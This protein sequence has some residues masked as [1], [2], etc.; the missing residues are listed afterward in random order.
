MKRFGDR[1]VTYAEFKDKIEEAKR[2]EELRR[3]KHPKE[4]RI[5]S[6]K[7]KLET[8]IEMVLNKPDPSSKCMKDLQNKKLITEAALKNSRKKHLAEI[9]EL[10]AK[11]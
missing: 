7:E 8:S 11:L 4:I 2:E 5:G 9:A 1:A 10:N 3:K 6:I